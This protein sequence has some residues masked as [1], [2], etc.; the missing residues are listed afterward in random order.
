MRVRLPYETFVR[1]PEELVD[2]W[3]VVHVRL[4]Q[5]VLVDDPDEPTHVAGYYLNLGLRS[6][7]D[8]V[9]RLI[10]EAIDDGSIDWSET[11]WEPVDQST[12]EE[13]VR[14][15]IRPVASGTWYR[16]GRAFYPIEDSDSAAPQ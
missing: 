3:A 2:F 9:P 13:P 11:S 10:E 15:R 1:E 4:H 8:D 16:S 6:A 14:K 7:S 5:P 12:L